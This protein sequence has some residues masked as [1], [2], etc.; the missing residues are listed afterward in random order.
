MPL[1]V[2]SSETAWVHKLHFFCGMLNGSSNSLLE[3]SVEANKPPYHLT[4]TQYH[5]EHSLSS[6][7]HDF[8][9]KPGK[10]LAAR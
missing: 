7:R 5:L 3:H 1:T 10:V 4:T 6:D 8:D 9:V 2:N